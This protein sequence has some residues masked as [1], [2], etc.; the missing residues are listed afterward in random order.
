MDHLYPEE[1]PELDGLVR[2]SGI[3]CWALSS[4]PT[5]FRTHD[6]AQMVTDGTL[7]IVPAAVFSCL[8][9]VELCRMLEIAHDRS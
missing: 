1:R 5:F 7:S 2:C 4:S 6:Y 3:L 8:I 9:F